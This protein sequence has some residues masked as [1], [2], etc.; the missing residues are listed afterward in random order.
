MAAKRKTKKQK[1]YEAAQKQVQSFIEE[2]PGVEL[3]AVNRTDDGKHQLVFRPTLATLDPVDAA[4]SSKLPD[5]IKQRLHASTIYRDQLVRSDL[6]LITTDVTQEAPKKL[7]KKMREYY[8]SKSVFGSYI[9][10]F[11]NMAISGFEND[12]EDPALKEFY[13]NWCEDID[14]MEILEWVFQE[15]YTT[16]F[17]NTYKVL[18]KYEPQVNRLPPVANAPQPKAPRKLK[19]ETREEYLLQKD[20]W[21]AGAAVER[22]PEESWSEFA[23]RKKRWSKGYVPIAYTVLNPEVIEIKGS[24]MFNQ[25]RVV[26]EPTEDM[27][28]LVNREDTKSPLTDAE[29]QLLDELPP[30]IKTAIKKQEPVELDP[31]M[32]GQIRYR[33][34]PWERYSV[35]KGARSIEDLELK[36]AFKHADWSAVDG[37]VSEVMVITIGDK[38]N[39]VLKDDDLRKVAAMFNHPQKAFNVVWNHT[40]KVERIEAK[41][42]DQIFGTS[43]YEQ[44]ERDISGSFGIPRA[45]VDGIMYGEFN[46]DSLA[47]ATQSLV[48]ELQYARRQVERWILRE[49]KQI[50]EAFGFDRIPSV[51]WNTMILKDEIAYKTLV[52]GLVDRR[53]ISYDTA[54]KLLG[55]DPLYEGGKLKEELPRVTKGELGLY[56]SPFQQSAQS[57]PVQK[58]QKTPKGTPSEGRPKNSPAPKTPSKSTP[59]GQTKQK[60]K[61]AASIEVLKDMTIEEIVELEKLLSMARE[62]KTEEL[63]NFITE[64][65][66]IV[67]DS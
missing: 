56:G 4:F 66:E 54:H 58:T 15:F 17:V 49:Y 12:C 57:S 5:E 55:F 42:L 59:Q 37:I 64:R 24:M 62:K 28:E 39:P 48:A 46:K 3:A 60:L 25:S 33:S 10:V 40:L 16:G 26:L 29:K 21:M 34:M 43:K 27:V 41:N 20:L 35:P 6:D 30:E 45:I 63:I 1:E 32:V 8:R 38:D 51:R 22:I 18:G 2:H 61:K 67:E 36:E 23:A 44:A 7:Y 52:Q 47:I 65:E 31:E 9:D 53:I 50:A 14:I 13:D 19:S 11:V